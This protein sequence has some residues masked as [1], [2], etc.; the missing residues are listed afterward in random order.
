MDILFTVEPHLEIIWGRS[1]FTKEMLL[2]VCSICL[3]FF[4]SSVSS[5]LLVIWQR[6]ILAQVIQLSVHAGNIKQVVILVLTWVKKYFQKCRKESLLFHWFREICY[7]CKYHKYGRFESYNRGFFVTTSVSS[8]FELK[9]IKAE[10]MKWYSNQ[11]HIPGWFY[12]FIVL[13]APCSLC[14]L[15]SLTSDRSP[16][17]CSGNVQS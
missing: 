1:I 16:A 11:R 3:C 2:T 15:S 7:K 6:K 4:P 10:K 13:A 5:E 17:P 12:L 8:K 14:N 9:K